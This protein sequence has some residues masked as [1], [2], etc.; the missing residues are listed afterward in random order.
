ML[1]NLLTPLDAFAGIGSV[2]LAILILL[3]MV[4]VHEL[5]HYIAGKILKFKIDEFSIGFGPTLFSR[6]SKKSGEKFSLR[7]IPL[8]GYCAFADETGLGEDGENLDEID[9]NDG[10]MPALS[11]GEV[12]PEYAENPAAPTT[13]GADKVDKEDDGNDGKIDGNDGQATSGKFCEMAPWKRI[14]VLVSGALMNYLLALVCIFISLFAFGQ[15]LLCPVKMAETNDIPA[16]YCLQEKDIILEADGRGVFMIT[17]LTSALKDRQAGEKIPFKVSRLQTDGTR[18]EMEILVQLR[19]ATNFENSADT[20]RLYAAL[21]VAQRVDDNG[22]VVTDESGKGVYYMGSTPYKYGFF[23]TIGNGFLYSFRIAGSIFRLLGEL[24]MGALGAESFGGPITTIT[25]TSQIVSRGVQPFLEIAA[26]IG[27]NL[28]VFNILPIPALD[29][30][31]VVFTTI[32]WIRGKPIDRKIEAGIHAV[33]F[34]L[35]FAFAIMVDILQ[36]L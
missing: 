7:L 20:D 13:N 3:A 18:Q 22:N 27:V 6:T 2:L 10:G 17:D 9:E 24:I 19:V 23:Q 33:G 26:F 12:F 34:I 8:G 1:E 32:E 16:E 15:L 35:I 5:G 14:V 25:L 31:K 36:F 21:G 29:G 4:T 11:V 28:A 30:S